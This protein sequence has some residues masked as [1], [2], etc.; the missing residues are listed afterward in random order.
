MDIM[1]TISDTVIENGIRWSDVIVHKIR[2]VNS[3]AHMAIL[4]MNRIIEI[5]L[6][7]LY[8]ILHL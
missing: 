8:T 7:T 2:I 3:R 1:N 5:T 6:I 4:M